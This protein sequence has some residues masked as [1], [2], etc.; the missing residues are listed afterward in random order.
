MIVQITSKRR[1]PDLI[2]FKYGQTIC[3]SGT[4]SG[5]AGGTGTG[6]SN[7][8]AGAN[9]VAMD[10]ILISNPYNVTRLIKQQVIRIIDGELSSESNTSSK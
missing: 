8:T 5:S 10:H 4:D 6:T 2:T 7:G 1:R 9:I 3:D